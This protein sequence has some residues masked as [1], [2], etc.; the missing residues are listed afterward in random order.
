M[1]KKYPYTIQVFEH[2]TIRIGDEINGVVF[3]EF[4]F[5]AL[6]KFSERIKSK[7]YTLI[8][9][10]VKFSH[11]V[12]ALQIGKLTIEILPK[13]DKKESNDSN[14]WHGV[15]LDMLKECRLLK[16]DT[17]S[18]AR[19]RLRSNSI[20]DLYFE[21]FLNEVEE[22]LRKGLCKSCLLYTSPSPRDS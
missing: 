19:L 15:L 6:T 1:Q 21:I 10:G 20:L 8:Y 4:H 22:L 2:Q 3:T 16:I 18:E 7:Y 5:N 17:T 9:K 12:G 13:A 14:L 11:Y